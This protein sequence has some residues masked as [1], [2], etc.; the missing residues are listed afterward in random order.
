MG[1][2][3]VLKGHELGT[4]YASAE[5]SGQGWTARVSRFP[6]ADSSRLSSELRSLQGQIAATARELSTPLARVAARY[7]HTA[8]DRQ[9]LLADVA[10]RLRA[11]ATADAVL[12][13]ETALR[14]TR[15]GDVLTRGDLLA[16][17]PF[18]NQLVRAVAPPDLQHSPDALTAHL[19]AYAGPMVA[20]PL[21]PPPHVRTVLT[22]GYLADVLDTS[23]EAIGLPL[24]QAVLHALTEG[25][26]VDP[27]RP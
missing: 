11:S 10:G 22:T 17:E 12:L 7:R 21:P 9:A 25:I 1:A 8:L 4:G 16:V 18:R 13:N 26:D 5:P 24:S 15:L 3:T 27:H 23:A 19:T 6:A 20:A 2:T 14:T